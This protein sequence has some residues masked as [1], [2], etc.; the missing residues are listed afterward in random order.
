M[1]DKQ[2][3]KLIK[4]ATAFKAKLIKLLDKAKEGKTITSEDEF[5]MPIGDASDMIKVCQLVEGN[6]IKAASSMVE[7]LDT[8]C[9]EKLPEAIFN[10]CYEGIEAI[11]E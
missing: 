5:W 6:K 8:S 9:R 4:T 10:L 7:E 2:T 3:Q 11:Y 1:T